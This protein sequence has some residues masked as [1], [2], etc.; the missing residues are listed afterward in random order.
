MVFIPFL[1]LRPAAV[2]NRV[3]GLLH[4]QAL[5]DEREVESSAADLAG[6][7][8]VIAVGVEAEQR[9][10]ESVLA[11]GGAVAASGVAA[12]LHEDRH[13]VELEADR[14]R[15]HRPLDVDG[16][17]DCAAGKCR[18]ERGIAVGK[19]L[20]LLPLED[21]SVGMGEI[22]RRLRR[23]IPRD[24]VGVCRLHDERLPVLRRGELNLLRRD[25]D[26]DECRIGTVSHPEGRHHH[27]QAGPKH[28]SDRAEVCCSWSFAVIHEGVLT[29]GFNA[30]VRP[31]LKRLSLTGE[32]C[33][34]HFGAP[35]ACLLWRRSFSSLESGLAGLAEGS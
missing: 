27:T 26:V 1:D 6:E 30:E 7:A 4:Q 20:E 31:R 13:H 32:G 16:H 10:P 18:G 15:L 14:G 22:Q 3:A 29:I 24:A 19:G 25:D 11:A 2:R 8:V 12:G 21:H 23:D 17:G 9:Q 35:P 34:C 33:L 5:L 28:R